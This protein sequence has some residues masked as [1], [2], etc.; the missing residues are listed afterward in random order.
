MTHSEVKLGPVHAEPPI[1][2]RSVPGR[3]GFDV[4]DPGDF[5]PQIP[6]HLLRKVPAR[7]PEVSE[8][9]VVRHFTRLSRQNYAVDLGMYP[10]GSCTMKYNPKLNEVAAVWMV[11]PSCTP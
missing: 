5:Q 9:D 4:K 8:I 11:S 10:L 1:F 2:E 7:L 3:Q 6:A